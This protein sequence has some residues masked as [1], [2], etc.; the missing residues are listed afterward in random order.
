MIREPKNVINSQLL[1]SPKKNKS[2]LRL[3]LLYNKISRAI[4]KIRTNPNVVLVRYE[5]LTAAPAEHFRQ[6]CRFLGIPYRTEYIDRVAAPEQIVAPHEYWKVK[7]IETDT[8]L[9]NNPEKWQQTLD[10]GLSEMV[11]WLTRS[12]AAEFDY[13]SAYRGRNVVRGIKRDWPKFITSTEAKKIFS[14]V[15]G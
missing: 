5:D 11:N 13:R 3:A 8:I 6:V 4:I 12:T 15:R 10:D 2:V 1:N 14:R 9:T 7:N